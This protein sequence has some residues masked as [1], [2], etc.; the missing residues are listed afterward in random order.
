MATDTGT[1]A[2][3][4]F[5][6]L[7]KNLSS[8]FGRQDSGKLNGRNAHSTVG[9]MR[10]RMNEMSEALGVL[11][12]L[13]LATDKDKARYSYVERRLLLGKADAE[14]FKATAKAKGEW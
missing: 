8:M 10:L 9:T 5:D 6:R 13:G 3:E 1:R 14:S 2:R 11:D 12:D 7:W 4:N